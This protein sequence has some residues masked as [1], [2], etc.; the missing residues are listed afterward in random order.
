MNGVFM[1]MQPPVQ[2]ANTRSNT[3]SS[4][5]DGSFDHILA[6]SANEQQR[7]PVSAQ[8]QQRR[9]REVPQNQQRP[10]TSNANEVVTDEVGLE[11]EA[12]ANDV[13]E[14]VVRDDESDESDELICPIDQMA[15]IMNL[16][17]EL[18]AQILAAMDIE[19][20]DLA[21]TQ[22][23]LEFMM[24]AFGA[25]DAAQLLNV[26]NM[27]VVAEA[28]E[29]LIEDILAKPAAYEVI[30]QS[31]MT[32]GYEA[33]KF[34]Q[35]AEMEAQL[36]TFENLWNNEGDMQ[37][38]AQ[39]AIAEQ[40]EAELE[41]VVAVADDEGVE[42]IRQEAADTAIMPELNVMQAVQNT[43]DVTAATAAEQAAPVSPQNIIDQIVDNMRFEVRG[44]LQEIRIS[45][46]PEHLGDLSLRIATQNGI[47]TAQFIAESQRIKEII[48]SNFNQLRDALTAQGIDIAEIDVSV[49]NSETNG[50]QQVFGAN[51]SD[52][53]IDDLMEQFAEDEAAETDEDGIL[54]SAMVDIRA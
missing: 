10:N 7:E 42:I 9:G 36:L 27:A 37:V 2:A 5:S 28:I 47:V 53:R 32:D 44:N 33:M 46:K 22:I 41:Q 1:P 51:V 39:R 24:K 15:Q 52:A 48:E 26:S 35:A 31:V 11:G 4:Q 30:A 50:E 13:Q 19:P 54:R 40:V 8:S 45:L 29:A 25:E 16:P 49:S 14:V 6:Q 38:L 12:V 18:V 23:K 43:G 21:D 34:A 3:R 17:A 20:V